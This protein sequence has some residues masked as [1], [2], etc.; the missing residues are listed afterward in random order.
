[1]G[2]IF[3]TRDVFAAQYHHGVQE[4]AE[5]FGVNEFYGEQGE[6]GVVSGLLP[7][8]LIICSSNPPLPFTQS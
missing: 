7:I 6:A 2:M 3:V 8:S 5:V 1:M 4:G